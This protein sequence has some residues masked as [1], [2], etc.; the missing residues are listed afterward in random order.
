MKT[1]LLSLGMLF[2]YGAAISQIISTDPVFPRPDQPLTITYD[3]S[4]GSGGLANLPVGSD[5]YAH[6]G[7]ITEQGGSGNWQYV[8]GNWGTVDSRVK[9]TRIGTSNLYQLTLGPTLV[10]WYAQNNNDGASIPPSVEV[11]ELGFVFRNADGSKEGK[12]AGNGDIFLTVYPTGNQLFA[13]LFEPVQKAIIAQMGQQIPVSGAASLPATLSLTDNGQLL[14]ETF[15]QTLDYA[16]DVTSGGFHEVIFSAEAQGQ[17]IAD[18]FTYIINPPLNIQPPPAGTEPGITYLNDSTIRLA[19]FAPQKAFVYVL[20]DFNNWTPTPEYFMNRQPEGR[21]WWLDITGLTPG[22][23]YAFQYWVD[24]EIRIADP[25]SE[26]VLD[27]R[28]DGGIPSSHFPNLHPYPVDK[29]TDY[30]SLIQPGKVPFNWQTQNYERPEKERLVV[31]ELLVRDFVSHR[32]YQTLMDSLDYLERLGVNAI[33]LMP[34]NEFNANLSWG[35]DPT[36]HMALDKYYGTPEAFKTFIDACHARGIAVI[37]DVVFNHAHERNPL[38]KLYWNQAQFRPAP[39]N[40]WLNQQATHAF[41]VFNDFNHEAQ[42]TK[43]YVSKILKYWV[44]EYRIDG[45]RVDL[46][47][48]FTQNTNG[49]FDAGAYDG[50]RIAIL[51]NYADEVWSVDPGVY[52]ILEHFAANAEERVL[53]DYGF[54]L[55]GNMNHT[56]NEATMGYPGS[57]FS[58]VSHKAR[59]WT[60][61]HLIGYME[62]HDEERLMFKNLTYGNSAPGYSVK[63]LTTALQRQELAANFFLTIPGPKMIWQFGELGYDHSIFTCS[64]GTVDLNDTGCKLSPKPVRWDYLLDNRRVHLFKVFAALNRLRNTYEVFHTN[65]FQLDLDQPTW[66]QIQLNS[67]E[68]DVNVIGNF[69]LTSTVLFVKFQHEG[70]WYDYYTGDS[71]FVSASSVPLVFQPGEYRL[72][73]DSKIETFDVVT[74]VQSVPQPISSVSLAPN[75]TSGPVNLTIQLQES[76]LVHTSVFNQNGQLIYSSG[77]RWYQAGTHTALLDISRKFVSG[78]VTIVIN[79][80]AQVWTET[81]IV[82]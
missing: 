76:A 34:V 16:I 54:L 64:D 15:G 38:C 82:H 67:A 12:T 25:Y 29:T 35:Y 72:Y 46:S 81:L 37:L 19:L 56:Y 50:S 44:E 66:K 48:G 74:S 51:K 8:V 49:P 77:A 30:V 9:M 73:T 2:Y 21:I 28:H 13:T 39:G 79:A 31:Y 41:N 32:T 55:W 71:L 33:E 65:D 7:L 14:T 69:G 40:P 78:P 3:A 17:T 45:Y 80:D 70:L 57:N 52:M 60:E 6:T 18:T 23:Q 5:V 11:R 4:K 68:M 42:P 75:P 10:D 58:G 36:F 26:L 47:K 62:S 22:Q 1:L 24:G 53:S 27:D 61:P 20:G 63:D 59:G 43:D